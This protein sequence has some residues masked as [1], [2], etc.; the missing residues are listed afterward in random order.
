MTVSRSGT[1]GKVALLVALV[2]SVALPVI[3]VTAPLYAGE[4]TT[5]DGAVS[6]TSETLVGMNG[7]HSIFLL[8]VPLLASILVG[9]ALVMRRGSVSLLAAWLITAAL[10]TAVVVSILS[11][12]IL[13]LPACVAL[14]VACAAGRGHAR[15]AVLQ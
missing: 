4:S 8:L 10:C 12:G 11:I 3:G 13:V 14:V 7:W 1:V 9:A 5:A 15:V 2:W 6:R